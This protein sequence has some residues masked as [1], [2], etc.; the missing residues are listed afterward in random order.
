MM[1]ARSAWILRLL[2]TLAAFVVIWVT[3][4][5]GQWQTGR[6]QY[7]E[8]LH[9]AAVSANAQAPWT[10]GAR[11]LSPDEVAHRRVVVQGEFLPNTTVYLDNRS[12]QQ[13][14]GVHV[15]TAFRPSERGAA[16]L[17]VNR[18]WM[19]LPPEQR[20]QVT[21]PAAPSGVVRL[22]GL[23]QTQVPSYWNLGAPASGKLGALWSN[24]GFDAYA[25][26]TGLS[27][28]PFV[29]LQTSQNADAL[30]RD[31][32]V[33]GSGA[34]KHRGYAFQWYSLCLLTLGWWLWFTF[35]PNKKAK[36]D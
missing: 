32:P 5:L 18:G 21:A 26:L 20:Q 25:Q 3:F 11:L 12:Y 34:E 10:L 33:A 14:P 17:V 23:A 19:P 7:K 15:L 4:S 13:R 9:A 30:V 24:F 36:V 16:M 2:P 22:E 6:A 27:L 31:W 8:R 29:V 1:L 35:K 28:Q